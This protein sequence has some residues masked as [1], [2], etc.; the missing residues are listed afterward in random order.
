MFFKKNTVSG[1]PTNL[2]YVY[3]SDTAFL[4]LDANGVEYEF[5]ATGALAA[6]LLRQVTKETRGM[7]IEYDPHDPITIVAFSVLK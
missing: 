2:Y 4:R 5:R 6:S 7:V 1:T 3:D